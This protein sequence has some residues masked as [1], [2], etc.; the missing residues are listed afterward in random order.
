MA[1]VRERAKASFENTVNLKGRLTRLTPE[2]LFRWN[3]IDCAQ[4]ALS[5]A[6][7]SAG[8]ATAD[9]HKSPMVW[10]GTN[11]EMYMTELTRIGDTTNAIE[12]AIG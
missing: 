6:Q 11:G 1:E 8:P 10:R 5:H 4:P 12:N 9:G 7:S 2:T 3:Y